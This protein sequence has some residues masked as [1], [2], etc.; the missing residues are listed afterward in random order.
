MKVSGLLH[1]PTTVSPE[2][3]PPLPIEQE[4]GWAHIQHICFRKRISLA[5]ARKKDHR[6]GPSMGFLL[7]YVIKL[8]NIV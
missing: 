7:N 5:I 1:D 3:Q 2:E 8:S 6:T 4:P